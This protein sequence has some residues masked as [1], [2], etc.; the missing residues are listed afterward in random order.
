MVLGLDLS[1]PIDPKDIPNFAGWINWNGFNVQ[2]DRPH[3]GFDYAACLT[4]DERI[5][6]G[7]PNGCPVRAI[8][9]GRVISVVQGPG[10]ARNYFSIVIEHSPNPE[11]PAFNGSGL[12]S[13]YVHV[14]PE[15][16]I[17]GKL[18]EKGDVIGHIV[19][20]DPKN[21]GNYLPHLHIEL[22]DP[23]SFSIHRPYGRRRDPAQIIPIS[24]PNHVPPG[25]QGKPIFTVP[26]LPKTPIIIANG[27]RSIVINP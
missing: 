13:G 25:E 10:T 11:M 7:L 5:V 17:M 16:E 1:P 3:Y 9:D 14:Y 18:V 4:T 6:F 26:S 20:D 24:T 22:Y 2:G 12:C 15:E 21:E 23:D 8:A 19:A 27:Y